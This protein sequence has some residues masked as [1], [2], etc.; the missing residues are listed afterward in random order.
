MNKGALRSIVYYLIGLGLTVLSYLTVDHTYARGPSLYHVVILLTILGGIGWLISAAVRYTF[1]KRSKDLVGTMIVNLL[2]SL[3]F[4]LFMASILR[5]TKR[6]DHSDI[7]EHRISIKK[8][9]DTTTMYD[10]ENIIYVK[11]K[12]SVLI[13]VD[14]TRSRE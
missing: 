10:G 8:S 9:G 12:D 3:G 1:V 14:S 13:F 5:H 11:V 2:V 4:V 6:D 7:K